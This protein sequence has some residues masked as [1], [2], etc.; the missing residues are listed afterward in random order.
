MFNKNTRETKIFADYLPYLLISLTLLLVIRILP[1][2]KAPLSSYGYDFGFYYTSESDT[3]G[4]NTLIMS[5][6]HALDLLP[7]TKPVESMAL[8][9]LK[10][11]SSGSCHD[12]IG[13]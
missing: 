5:M 4:F 7:F 10:L 2:L 3:N 8:D 12:L 1:S 6:F 11:N 13:R 9:V